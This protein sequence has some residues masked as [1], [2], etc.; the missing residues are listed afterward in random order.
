RDVLDGRLARAVGEIDFP[1]K[2]L[3]DHADLSTALF[4]TT[5]VDQAGRDDLTRRDRC[6]PADGDEHTSFAGDLDD[7]PDNAWRIVCAIDDEGIANLA[8][9][10]T[11]RVE[12][13]TAR[14]TGDEDSRGTHTTNLD[15]SRQLCSHRTRARSNVGQW[16]CELS[17]V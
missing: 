8:A 15:S 14:E 2:D 13:R 9:P 16:Q 1:A 7:Q 11:R 5:Q 17:T 3:C 12:H 4:E 10:V 6:H